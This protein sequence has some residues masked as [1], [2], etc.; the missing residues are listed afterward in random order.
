MV[1]LARLPGMRSIGVNYDTG[2]R[3]EGRSTRDR[4]DPDAVQD[5]LTVIVN[6]LHA[7]AVRVVGTELDRLVVAG[8]AAPAAGVD[9]WLSPMA[10]E[11]EPPP[12]LA[13][14]TGCAGPA[15]AVRPAAFGAG[16]PGPRRD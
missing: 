11:L 9:L 1:T 5:E 6:E 3:F 10:I 16:V 12:F 7:P 15:E 13:S 2:L 4:F 14:L 8:E